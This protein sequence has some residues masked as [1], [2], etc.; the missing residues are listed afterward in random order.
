MVDKL[1]IVFLDAFTTNPGD[2]DWAN[3]E[4]LGNFKSYPY[5]SEDQFDQRAG[6]ADVLISNKFVLSEQHIN[7]LDKLKLICVAA[8]G[9]NNIDKEAAAK[10]D[11]PVKNVANYSTE[12]VCQHVFALLFAELNRV[13][14]HDQSVKLGDWEASRDFSYSLLPIENL[15]GKTFGVVGFGNI[16]QSVAKVASAFGMKVIAVNKYPERLSVDYV[17]NHDLKYV[18]TE[19]D[20]ISLHV[21][22]N[23]DTHEL[24]NS[25]S[26][27]LM[28][29]WAIL[30]NTGRGSL[31]NEMDLYHALKKGRIRAACLDVLEQEPPKKRRP[32]F[33]LAN[34]IITPHV[35]WAGVDARK[36]LVQ[37]IFHN[38]QEWQKKNS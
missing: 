17:E 35:A 18:L 36:R 14:A 13:E 1:N 2:I 34:C 20:V 24:I 6:D 5:T 31:I 11:I 19:S 10:R 15:T 8:T 33:E 3:L 7:R 29:K 28:K 21:P 32:L 22:L 16:G 38:I 37:G 4:S 27:N 12:S 9:T 30:I 26:L 25:E 23:N